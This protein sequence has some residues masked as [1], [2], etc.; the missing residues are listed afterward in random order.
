MNTNETDKNLKE[1]F[2]FNAHQIMVNQDN[3]RFDQEL[4]NEPNMVREKSFN[5]SQKLSVLTKIL[6][7]TV[8][9]VKKRAS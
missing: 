3:L 6:N 1:K 4:K 2:S 9:N 8:L 7:K 5:V